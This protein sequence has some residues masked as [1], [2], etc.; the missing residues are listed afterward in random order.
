MTMEH[1]N[2]KRAG[3]AFGFTAT[4]LYVGCALLMLIAGHAGT[5]LLFNSLLHGLDV[6]TIT[7]MDVPIG[8]SI[9]GLICTFLLGWLVG[10]C[11]AWIYNMGA[12]KGSAA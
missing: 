11:I 7:R 3:L 4:L 10:S 6:S 1:M 8:E 9:M 5:A 12:R 2:N